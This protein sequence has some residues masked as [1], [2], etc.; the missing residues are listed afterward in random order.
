MIL[1]QQRQRE[2]LA[3]LPKEHCSVLAGI[4]GK[5]LQTLVRHKR[6]QE[7]T[8]LFTTQFGAE[9]LILSHINTVRSYSAGSNM[10]IGQ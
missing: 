3:N 6:R 8:S 1:A 5:D 9:W 4:E 2:L 7:T 10:N